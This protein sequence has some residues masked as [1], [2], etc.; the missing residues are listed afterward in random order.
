MLSRSIGTFIIQERSV[1][2]HSSLDISALADHPNLRKNPN[3]T[4][5]TIDELMSLDS[6]VTEIIIDNGVGDWNF[7]VLDLSRFTR[8][9][10]LEIGNNSL[11][12]VT[13]VNIIGLSA[14][15]SVKIGKNSFVWFYGV[16]RL[17]YCPLLMIL[18]IN[19]GSF[20]HYTICEIEGTPAM[21]SIIIGD[22]KRYN[23]NFRSAFS[24]ELKGACWRREWWIDMPLLNSLSFGPYAFQY[25]DRA[26]FESDWS[27]CA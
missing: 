12:Y 15:L 16:F 17:K 18:N 5:K 14:L 4:V 21:L 23:F 9:R 3:A 22:W 20:E 13:T 10:T 7:T 19:Y 11:C 26:V 24:L 8:L 2:L 27:L 25:C 6:S 1:W